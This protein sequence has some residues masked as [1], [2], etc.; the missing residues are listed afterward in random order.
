M[1][2]IIELTKTFGKKTVLSEVN[3]KF[4]VGVYGLLGPNGAGK[5]TLL[6]SMLGL[7]KI[8]KG[9]ILYNNKSIKK[10]SEFTK[11]IGYLPQTFGLFKE[12]TVFD[13]MAYLAT[14]K[15]IE[16]SKQKYEIDKCIDHVNMTEH[17]REK[18][19]SLSGGMVRRL[20]IAQA[21]LG[22][23]QVVIVDEPTAGLDPEERMR[24]KNLISLIKENRA[25][26]IS[27]HI[28]ED[29]EALCSDI[30]ILDKGKIV[31]SGNSESICD[32]ALNKVYNVSAMEEANLKGTFIIER[33]ECINGKNIL[34]VISD[35]IQNGAMVQPTIE[36]GYMCRIK[37]LG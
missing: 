17:L 16:Q 34:R 36:D 32:I 15:G 20:G 25:I 10:N 1:I 26:V 21:L 30:V 6:R 11:K 31:G 4:N 13:M 18:V 9:D 23:P 37:G 24:F 2:D 22:N 35:T 7:Y 33:R 28:V 19:G 14:L 29:V 8:Q 12:I 3:L 5:T 27:T